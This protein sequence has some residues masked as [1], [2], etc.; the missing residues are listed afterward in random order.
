M[1]Y[2]INDI[3]FPSWSTCS[4]VQV[5]VAS[6]N[7][8]FWWLCCLPQV[9]PYSIGVETKM[10]YS[11]IEQL[12]SFFPNVCVRNLA[13]NQDLDIFH[14]LHIHVVLKQM[15]TCLEVNCCSQKGVQFVG[16]I[17][18]AAFCS[19]PHKRAHHPKNCNQLWKR[20]DLDAHLHPLLTNYSYH[21]V[22]AQ[23]FSLWVLI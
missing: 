6:G 4:I 15:N 11:Y 5:M 23:L 8:S 18:D 1:H 12:K 20:E 2:C 10:I 9:H 3:F 22:M 19:S 17:I 7:W 14:S 13:L 16:N 21:V